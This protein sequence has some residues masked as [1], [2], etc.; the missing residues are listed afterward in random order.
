MT[1]AYLFWARVTP[2]SP[3]SAISEDWVLV[4]ES[5]IAETDLP[6]VMSSD[7]LAEPRQTSRK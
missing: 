2:D 1:K 6:E 3:S 4:C 5:P 7:D